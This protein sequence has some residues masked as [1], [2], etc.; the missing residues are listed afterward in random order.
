L[1]QARSDNPRDI[2]DRATQN[3]PDYERQATTKASNK[4]EKIAGKGQ[5]FMNTKP[6][7]RL[8]KKEQRRRPRIQAGLESS[9]A[10]NQWSRAVVSWV[11]EI[12]QHRRIESLPTFESL[13]KV[14]QSQA[15][16]VERSLTEACNG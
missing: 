6:L 9:D 15:G 13:F 4:L 5:E 11:D 10:P 2:A 16:Q 14:S 8:I 1:D 3:V 12:Q 7:I